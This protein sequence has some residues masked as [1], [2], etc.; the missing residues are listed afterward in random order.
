MK[1]QKF[2]QFDSYALIGDSISWKCDGFDLTAT[3]KFDEDSHVNDSD[4]YS[5]IKIKQWKNDEWFFVG[6]VISA[7]KNSVELLDHAASIWGTECN[8]NKTSNKHLAHL[9][10]DMESEAV[11]AGKLEIK[12][13]CTALCEANT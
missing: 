6:V 12:R 3:L 5:P 7:S 11:D 8:F 13:M 2:P 4:C 9:A 10:R 1:K